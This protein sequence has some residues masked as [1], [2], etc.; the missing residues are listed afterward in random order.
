LVGEW[1]RRPFG[2]DDFTLFH[3]LPW[4]CAMDIFVFLVALGVDHD[5]FPQRGSLEAAKP[6]TPGGTLRGLAVTGWET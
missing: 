2:D 6:G 5:I 1:I 4:Y 3:E